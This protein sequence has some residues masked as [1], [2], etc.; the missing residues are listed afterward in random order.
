MKKQSPRPRARSSSSSSIPLRHQ[1]D[2]EVPTVIHNPEEKMNALARL[3][4]RIIKHP[5]KYAIWVLGILG[6][7]LASV[8]FSNWS[9]SGPAKESEVWTKLYAETKPED[10]AETAKHYPGTAAS[11]WALLRAASEYY[12]LG[13]ADLPN[14]RD[15]AVSNVDR[16]RA[17]YEQVEK[18]APKDSFQAR[19]AALGVARC[20][21][22]RNEL[23]KAIEQYENVAASWPDSPEAGQAKQLAETL[24][25]P[26]AVA[27]YKELFTYNPPKVTLPPFG[28]ER[29]NFPGM[30]GGASPTRPGMTSPSSTVPPRPVEV[31]PPDI[32]EIRPAP[33][34]GTG[35]LPDDV[36]ARPKQPEPKGK[37]PPKTPQ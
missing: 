29:L 14:N 8:I 23:A 6:V 30:P 20:W 18:D 35:Q 13:M 31:T 28:D 12:N 9:S 2:H 36:F 21:E 17:L 16:A 7:V 15:V 11:Q 1:F 25:K 27:F 24:K 37:T 10:L 5:E 4:H 22:A 33:A 3:A 32:S 26:E 34:P 19:V